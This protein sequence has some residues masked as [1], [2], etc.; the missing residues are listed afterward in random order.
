MPSATQMRSCY[1]VSIV[2]SLDSLTVKG[3][4]SKTS[5]YKEE[6]RAASSFRFHSPLLNVFVEIT[7]V[8]L[9]SRAARFE[10]IHR[11]SRI[12]ALV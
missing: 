6:L 8:Q 11:I 7:G 4:R 12:K 1:L 5:S 3:I 9:W 2:A 10:G